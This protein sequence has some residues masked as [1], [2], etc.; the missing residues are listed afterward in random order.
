MKFITLI[1]EEA[2]SLG[3]EL[4]FIRVL[5]NQG[6]ESTFKSLDIIEDE[7]VVPL[8]SFASLVKYDPF[9]EPRDRSMYT[10]FCLPL[11]FL[12][13]TVRKSELNK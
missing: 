11:V 8:H 6:I 7:S 4:D 5:G 12:N 3:R 13:Q 9:F 1:D 10:L 2:S